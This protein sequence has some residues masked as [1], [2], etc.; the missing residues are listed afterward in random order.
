M[1]FVGYPKGTE[2]GKLYN[3]LMGLKKRRDVEFLE[4]LNNDIEKSLVEQSNN[5]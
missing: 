1:Y 5:E 2:S 4:E 3:T